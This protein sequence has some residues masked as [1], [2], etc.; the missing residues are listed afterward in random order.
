MRDKVP[1]PANSC[2]LSRDLEGNLFTDGF[3]GRCFGGIQAMLGGKCLGPCPMIC[4]EEGPPDTSDEPRPDRLMVSPFADLLVNLL[5]RGQIRTTRVSI[6]NFQE[7]TRISF[8]RW[9]SRRVCDVDKTHDRNEA[10]ALFTL[11]FWCLEVARCVKEFQRSL[12]GSLN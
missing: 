9:W 5:G 11:G 12:G 2:Q 10:R 3:V 1:D 7:G 4:H 8:V 6:A